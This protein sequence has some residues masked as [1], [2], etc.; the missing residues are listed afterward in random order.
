ML[1]KRPEQKYTYHQLPM[2]SRLSAAPPVSDLSWGN[3]EGG[4][5]QSAMLE[6]DEELEVKTFISA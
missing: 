1:Q 2:D 3:G 6:S 5:M 4:R